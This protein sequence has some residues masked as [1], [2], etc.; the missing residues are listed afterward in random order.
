MRASRFSKK[1]GGERY[2]ETSNIDFW[3]HIHTHTH[4]GVHTEAYT[5]MHTYACMC[6][7]INKKSSFVC[8]DVQPP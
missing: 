6:A 7:H 8:L 4:R 2:R 1:Y 3:S 5:H